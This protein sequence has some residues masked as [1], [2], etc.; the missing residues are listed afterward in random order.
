MADKRTCPECGEKVQGRA[1]KRFCGDYCRN[2]ANNKLN[3]DSSALMRNINNR[4]RKNYRVLDEL[5]PKGKTKT[6]RNKLL[7]MG[8][9]FNF[10]TSV[11]TTKKGTVYHFVYDQGY[12]N[13][14][15][16]YFLLVKRD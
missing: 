8:F 7:S 16:D 4:L 5:N 1:D 9:D 11:Y 3:R 2:V 12:L 14:D 10:I 13:T 15:D 6:T